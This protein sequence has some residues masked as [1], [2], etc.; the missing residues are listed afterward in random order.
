MIYFQNK[1]EPGT[2]KNDSDVK[3]QMGS[4]R[5]SWNKMIRQS[6]IEEYLCQQIVKANHN[7]IKE[8]RRTAGSGL[9]R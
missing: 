3:M 2:S 6:N 9:F 7:K 1:N 4:V 5:E 8:I